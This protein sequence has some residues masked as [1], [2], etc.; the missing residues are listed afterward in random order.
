MFEHRRTEE[1]AREISDDCKRTQAY[2]SVGIRHG[3]RHL[4][5]RMI[6]LELGFH[7][8]HRLQVYELILIPSCAAA[9]ACS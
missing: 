1:D 5:Q 2:S 6:H 4:G 8:A 3:K 9:E 7:I